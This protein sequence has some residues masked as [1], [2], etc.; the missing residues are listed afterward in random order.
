MSHV[1][2]ASSPLTSQPPR[3][4]PTGIFI[5]QPQEIRFLFPLSTLTTHSQLTLLTHFKIPFH[6]ALRRAWS[7]LRQSTSRTDVHR[8]SVEERADRSQEM[9]ADEDVAEVDGTQRLCWDEMLPKIIEYLN[10]AKHLSDKTAILSDSR[11]DAESE[12]RAPKANAN[13][14][15]AAWTNM[16]EILLPQYDTKVAAHRLSAGWESKKRTFAGLKA[17]TNA[18]GSGLD[19]VEAQKFANLDELIQAKFPQYD[20]MALLLGRRPNV[21]PIVSNAAHGQN[22]GAAL[23]AGGSGRLRSSYPGVNPV[24]SSASSPIHPVPGSSAEAGSEDS[25]MRPASPGLAFDFSTDMFGPVDFL[26]PYEPSFPFIPDTIPDPFVNFMANPMTPL[27]ST[28]STSL[29]PA[30]SSTSNLSLTSII[31]DPQM[32]STTDARNPISGPPLTHYRESGAAQSSSSISSAESANDAGFSQSH[33][34]SSSRS[35]SQARTPSS[36]AKGKKRVRPFSVPDD[37]ARFA[38]AAKL[39]LP[40]PTD[41]LAHS[42]ERAA[43]AATERLAKLNIEKQLA[44]RDTYLARAKMAEAELALLREQRSVNEGRSGNTRGSI[45][46][47]FM[48]GMDYSFAPG[49]AGGV[50]GVAGGTRADVT[51]GVGS[52]VTA[53]GDVA[54]GSGASNMNF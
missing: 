48:N 20:A 53:A 44:I 24:S 39:D 15:K 22:L 25:D 6:T 13:R 21:D 17:R 29:P 32:F 9:D 14:R 18:T 33:T 30:R 2:R 3:S 11:G 7:F 54:G 26:Q 51:D 16:A 35:S 10:D 38:S 27:R 34:R 45:N 37:I 41:L 49:I 19:K 42:A 40:S 36:I 43:Q 8:D 12:H 23:L 4:R 46:Y 28:S 50:Q 31:E 47:D 5:P 1:S 52:G